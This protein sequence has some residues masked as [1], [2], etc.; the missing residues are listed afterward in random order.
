MSYWGLDNGIIWIKRL[1]VPNTDSSNSDV[2]R[3]FQL[4]DLLR[5]FAALWVGIYHL[6]GGHGWFPYLKHPYGNI[7]DQGKFGALSPLIRLGFL[8]VPIFFVISGFVIVT[9]SKKKSAD[10]FLIARFSRLVPGFIFSLALTLSVCKFGFNPPVSITFEKLISTLNLSW[11]P[12]NSSPIQGSYWTLWPEVRFY[13]LFF[14]FVLIFK[15]HAKFERKVTIF[16]IGWLCTLWLSTGSGTLLG[17]I[18]IS[19]YA[20]YFIL[21]GF[22]AIASN[23]KKIAG[24]LPFAFAGLLIAVINLRHWIIDWDP[25]HQMDWSL[26]CVIFLVALLLIGVSRRVKFKDV[27]VQSTI[28]ILGKASYTFYLLQEGFGIPITSFLVFHG[29]QIRYAI[30][31]SMIS[32]LAIS[33]VFTIWVECRVIKSLKDRF[34]GGLKELLER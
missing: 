2:H 6:S 19:D 10:E 4:L 18:S 3:R 27:W 8:G 16:F 21:G 5:I 20:I 26:G 7:L 22:I 28:S 30:G 24:I 11:A 13:G 25:K 33:V 32:V 31:F 14:V 12:S 34:G 9:S 1:G 17:V 23:R 29:M 15:K